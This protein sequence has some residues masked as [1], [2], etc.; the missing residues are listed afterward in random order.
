MLLRP[1]SP[2]P[3]LRPDFPKIRFKTHRADAESDTISDTKLTSITMSD[4]FRKRGLCPIS[5]PKSSATFSESPKSDTKSSDTK[6][7]SRT[8]ESQ[9]GLCDR[10]FGHDLRC[11]SLIFRG[12]RW[13]GTPEGH[14]IDRLSEMLRAQM[15]VPLGLFK[16]RVT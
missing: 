11:G 8:N 2:A 5:V 12:C 13:R 3:F 6:A 16:P 10:R 1:P 15:R 9:R 4:F 14:D 7:S